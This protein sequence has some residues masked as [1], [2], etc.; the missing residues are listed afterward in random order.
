MCNFLPN[1]SLY[2]AQCND[3]EKHHLAKLKALTIIYILSGLKLY[4]IYKNPESSSP[5][6][7][8][9]G[10]LTFSNIKY[11][12]LSP[13][14]VFIGFILKPGVFLSI[15]SIDNP[16]MPGPPVLTAVVK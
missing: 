5:I 12:T 9:H 6:K 4:I 11:V 14:Y 15:R 16:F 10:T 2:I 8:L 7:F 13:P 3:S 1:E